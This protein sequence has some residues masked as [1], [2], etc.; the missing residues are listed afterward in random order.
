M[1]RS[2]AG[3][4]DVTDS[5]RTFR[6]T[7]V[8]VDNAKTVIDPVLQNAVAIIAEKDY[9]AKSLISKLEKGLRTTLLERLADEGILESTQDSFLIVFERTRWP[10]VDSAHE[11]DVRSTLDAVLIDGET[12]DTRTGVLV[13]LLNE[14]GQAHKIIARDGVSPKTVKQ[15]SAEIAERSWAPDAVK[16]AIQAAQV[17]GALAGAG[18]T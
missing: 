1:V 8:T 9:S 17:P 10:A 13:A 6:S 12:P 2:L 5:D 4:A 3:V 15:R 11:A 7:H 16:K 14:L 18:A